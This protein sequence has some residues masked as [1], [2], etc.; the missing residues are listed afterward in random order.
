MEVQRLTDV[1]QLLLLSVLRTGEDAH[2][3]AV[4]A[5]L[6]QDGERSSSLGSIYVTMTRLEERGMVESYLGEPTPERGG[7]ARRLYR[8]TPA[9]L[10]ALDRSRRI[11]ERMW[12]GTPVRGA[13]AAGGEAGA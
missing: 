5:V 2:A 12:R 4:K 11:W 10:Q 8:V 3:G 1:E 13:S 9:G 7:K 6:E